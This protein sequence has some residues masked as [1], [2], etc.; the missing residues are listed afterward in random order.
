MTTL[1]AAAAQ[2]NAEWCDAFC[3]AHGV[4]GRFA[5]DCWAAPRRT[6]PLYPDAVTLVPGVSPDHVL[7]R[8]DGGA[9]CSVK[10]SFADLELASHGFS[11]LFAAEWLQCVRAPPAHRRWA[12][13]SDTGE[14]DEWTAAWAEQPTGFF[15]PVLLGDP[16]IRVLLTRDG[17]GSIHAGAIAKRSADVVGISNV[18]SAGGDLPSS[19]SGAAAAA[20]AELGSVPVVTYASGS[21]LVAARV[22]G[23]EPVGPLRVWF[24]HTAPA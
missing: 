24:H 9:G 12:H 15:P 11:L 16:S 3:R 13:V 21:E 17:D 23:F 5:A 14:L 22:A 1:A 19:W 8:V 6:P 18:F 4:D 2:N 20:Q 7:H 10:D